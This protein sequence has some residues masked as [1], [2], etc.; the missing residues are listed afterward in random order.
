MNKKLTL[1]WTQYL[2]AHIAD[3]MA[4]T[5]EAGSFLNQEHEDC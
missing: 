5:I 3:D 2:L 4:T 1:S